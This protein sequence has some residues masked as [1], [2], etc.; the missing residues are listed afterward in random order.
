MSLENYLSSITIS[1]TVTYPDFPYNPPEKYPEFGGA[2]DLD[3]DSRNGVYAQVRQTLLDLGL[4]SKRAG[5]ADWNPL[6]DFIIPGETV[7]LKPNWVKHTN[8]KNNNSIDE[9]ITHSSIVR[10]MLDYAVKALDGKGKVVLADAP[11]QSCRFEDLIA[12]VRADELLDLYRARYPKIKFSLVDLR[13]TVMKQDSTARASNYDQSARDGDPEGY[14]LVNI[15]PDSLLVDIA[16]YS[17]RFRVTHYDYR[18]LAPHHTKT[19]NEYL[20]ANSIL[21]ADVIINLPKM[22]CHVKAGLTGSLKNLIGINGHKEYLPHH[23]NGSPEDH[24]DQYKYPSTLKWWYNRVYDTFWTK[25]KKGYIQTKLHWL[26]LTTLIVLIRQFGRDKLLDGGWYG[27]DTIPRTTIDLN[28]I[29]YFWDL[30]TKKLSNTPQRK[31]FHLIDG[32]IAGEDNGPLL[33]TPKPVG[34]MIAGFNPLMTDVAMGKLMGYDIMQINTLAHGLQHT[35]SRLVPNR[36]SDINEL[37]VVLNSK[38]TT[39]NKLPTLNFVKPLWW[40]AVEVKD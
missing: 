33:P 34:V 26:V 32:I 18:L 39:L 16:E 24:G 37:P 31:V 13:K 29:L 7:L 10:V 9:L 5:K 2:K 17:D 38:K 12:R 3:L 23:T 4:D 6:G 35:Q 22:K 40:R 15:G 14:S 19:V 27:N 1:Q 11:L 28:N 8:P 20:V 30:K 21:K 36:V 25:D